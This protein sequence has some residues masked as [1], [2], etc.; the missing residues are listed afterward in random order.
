MPSACR[1]HPHNAEAGDAQ[2]EGQEEGGRATPLEPRHPPPGTTPARPGTHR[3][4]FQAMATVSREQAAEQSTPWARPSPELGPRRPR[5]PSQELVTTR[6]PAAARAAPDTPAG[7]GWGLLRPPTET[8]LIPPSP[9]GPRG[10]AATPGWRGP[11]ADP[12]A[13]DANCSAVR[14]RDSPL[15]GAALGDRVPTI[16]CDTPQLAQRRNL[17]TSIKSTSPLQTKHTTHKCGNS[18]RAEPCTCHETHTVTQPGEL[19]SQHCKGR[20]D[21]RT[22]TWKPRDRKSVV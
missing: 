5:G 21:L 10:K 2:Y 3:P 7:T 12:E 15:Q 6:R 1:L 13:G 11:S 22:A 14:P 18:H 16:R 4:L 19:T 20:T 9:G 17:T 8:P